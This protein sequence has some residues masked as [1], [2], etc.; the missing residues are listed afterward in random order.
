[1]ITVNARDESTAVLGHAAHTNLYRLDFQ[2][3]EEKRYIGKLASPMNQN[4]SV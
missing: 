2:I 1:M 4:V 3:R